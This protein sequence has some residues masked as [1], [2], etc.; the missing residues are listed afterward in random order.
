[1][2]YKAKGSDKQVQDAR[3]IFLG[4]KAVSCSKGEWQITHADATKLSQTIQAVE[5]VVTELY[6]GPFF[7]RPPA[8]AEA[9]KSQ[10]SWKFSILKRFKNSER[11]SQVRLLF[12]FQHF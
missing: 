1:M 8:Y 12:S 5:C 9:Q 2:G 7:K 3:K 11:L 4:L 6:L 10:A